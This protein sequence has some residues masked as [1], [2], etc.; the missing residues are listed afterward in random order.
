MFSTVYYPINDYLVAQLP[1]MPIVSK[2]SGVAYNP[3]IVLLVH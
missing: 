3:V 1:H 2:K